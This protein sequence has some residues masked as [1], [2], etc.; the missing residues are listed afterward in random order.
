MDLF[1]PSIIVTAFGTAVYCL[2]LGII[3]LIYSVKP[4]R[5][6]TVTDLALFM[7]LLSIYFL[8]TSIIFF[9]FGVIDSITNIYVKFRDKVEKNDWKGKLKKIVGWPIIVHGPVHFVLCSLDFGFV[10]WGSCTW[11]SNMGNS[12][13]CKSLFHCSIVFI[14]LVAG[15]GIFRLSLWIYVTYVRCKRILF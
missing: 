11:Y 10:I 6:G 4:Y 15:L 1:K 5:E 9:I 3:G 2:V 7:I 13:A 8:I 14:M 12:D